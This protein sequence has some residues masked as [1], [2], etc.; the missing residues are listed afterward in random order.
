MFQSKYNVSITQ[1][2]T[3][4]ILW[5]FFFCQ[6]LRSAGRFNITSVTRD[7]FILLT[8]W[9]GIIY[10]LFVCFGNVIYLPFAFRSWIEKATYG[11]FVYDGVTSDSHYHNHQASVLE[12]IS[13]CRGAECTEINTP[14]MHFVS[15]IASYCT[16]LIMA[17]VVLKI[18]ETSHSHTVQ[19]LSLVTKKRWNK[20]AHIERTFLFYVIAK[21]R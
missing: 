21:S 16:P 18:C 10:C 13:I 9:V 14:R 3:V 20:S 19:N 1:K 6:S 4:L 12:D 5:Y 11:T 15:F 17:T 2:K 8:C 7:Y